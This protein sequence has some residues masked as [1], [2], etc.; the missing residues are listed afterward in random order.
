MPD[1]LLELFSEQIPARMQARAASDLQ[2][3]VTDALV[4][5]R[6]DYE[7][8]VSFSTPHRLCLNLSG[9]ALTSHPITEK[10]KGPRVDA[11]N[12]AIDGFLC[13]SRLLRDHLEICEDDKGQ[14][15]CA[16]IIQP[17]RSA[18]DIIAEAI[19][20]II[21]KFPW[22]K[23]M[24][25]GQGQLRWIRPLHSIL[26][27]LYDDVSTSVVDFNVNGIVSTNMTFGNQSYAKKSFPVSSFDDY[28]SK[29][30]NTYVILDP[31]DRQQKI[32]ADATNLAFIQGLEVVEDKFLLDEVTRLVEW[33]VVLMGDIDKDFLGLP[34]EVLQ[35]SMKKH[36]KFFSVRNPRTNQIEKFIIVANRETAD[37]GATILSGNKKVLLA[38]LSDAKF[39]WENDLRIS[40]EDMAEKLGNVIFHNKLG[41][42]AER[43]ERISALSQALALFLGAKPDL[44][45][46]A[47]KFCKADL[48]S[49]MVYEF[50][51]LQG[52]MGRYYAEKAGLPQVL[53]N[54]SPEHYAPLGPS[55]QVPK[56]VLSVIVAI[57]DKLDKLTAFWTIDEKP[58][59]SKDP[60]A[61]RRA[62]IGLIRLILENDLRIEIAPFIEKASMYLQS[63]SVLKSISY[64]SEQP[65]VFEEHIRFS[66][67]I[68]QDIVLFLHNRLKVY[69]KDQ[70]LSYDS[71]EACCSMP[72][73]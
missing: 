15:Y 65:L 71:I 11:P 3:L 59:G 56:N 49:E 36:Q 53:A 6:L 73:K 22:P 20:R 46:M 24:R 48:C 30:Q 21:R 42:E 41:T 50:P 29:L 34:P 68:V 5:A 13:R 47:T 10:R 66:K 12:K 31:L 62:A 8:S 17:G 72:K 35:I 18:N 14:F 51:E 55:D 54:I 39:F 64:S 26:C 61:L 52:I 37:K 9:V 69:L 60:F 58:T 38:R 44:L 33:P 40:L 70:G 16:K 67:H 63:Q 2:T 27:I 43:V 7:G 45:K 25:W 4:S 57:A 23:S 32:W 1:L 28:R 19:P